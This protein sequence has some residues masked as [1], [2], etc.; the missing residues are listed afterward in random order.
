[1][2]CSK[3]YAERKLKGADVYYKNV[4]CAICNDADVTNL[5]CPGMMVPEENIEESDFRDMIE[6]VFT[7][8]TWLDKELAKSFECSKG[9]AY[10]PLR[11]K[12]RRDP[13]L[14]KVYVL[15]PNSSS[16]YRTNSLAV[17]ATLFVFICI[18][19]KEL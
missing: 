16:I 19:R 9:F 18:L 10:D 5:E 2:L 15:A 12:C 11:T 6:Q 14:S 7:Q 4:H 17:L 3:Y 13:S 1:M 8:G